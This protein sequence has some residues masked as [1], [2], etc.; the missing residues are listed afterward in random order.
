MKKSFLLIGALCVGAAFVSCVDDSESSEVKELRQVQLDQK[1]VALDKDYWN[2]YNDAVKKVK[3]LQGELEQ[4]QEDLDGVKSGKLTAEGAKAA[5]VAYWQTVIDR[6]QK[7]IDDINAEIAVQEKMAG[8]S[9]EEVQEAKRT[10][11]NAQEKAN[12]EYADYWISLVEKG[13][14]KDYNGNTVV[15]GASVND[16]IDMLLKKNTDAVKYKNNKLDEVPFVKAMNIIFSKETFYY[17]YDGNQYSST[18]YDFVYDGDT[19]KASD[20][21]KSKTYTLYDENGKVITTYQ[22]WIFDDVKQNDAKTYEGALS[23]KV[24]DASDAEKA[25]FTKLQEDMTELFAALKDNSA[26]KTLLNEYVEHAKKLYALSVASAN[27]TTIYNAYDAYNF[28]SN[29]ED[30]IAGLQDKIGAANKLNDAI[31]NANAKINQIDNDIVDYAT[32]QKYFEALVAELNSQIAA[33]K[34]IADKYRALIAGS[35]SSNNNQQQNTPAPE[36]EETPA[37]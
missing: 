18:N 33:N 16:K 19:Y 30:V 23:A 20:M 15:L 24:K 27:A 8:K 26:Y 3:D 31:K 34:A 29:N 10:A 28:A 36:P 11:K 13:Y 5:A 17:E 9:Y 21:F 7:D 6:T 35:E 32:A 12:K 37:E 2:M 25:E 22:E 4:A 1:K 14:N